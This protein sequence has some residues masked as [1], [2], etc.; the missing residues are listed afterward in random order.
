MI[1]VFPLWKTKY[2]KNPELDTTLLWEIYYKNITVIENRLLLEIK[3]D[4]TAVED[5]FWKR[6][7]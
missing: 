5:S 7:T 1:G 6:W 2:S 4:I 3:Y